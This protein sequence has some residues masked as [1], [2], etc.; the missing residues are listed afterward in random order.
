MASIRVRTKKD[1]TIY[2]AVLFREQGK[3]RSISVADPREAARAKK[4]IEQVGPTQAREILHIQDTTIGPDVLTTEQWLTRHIAALTGVEQATRNRYTGYV[5]RDITPA[6]GA[7]PLALLNRDHIAAWVNQL[8]G[9]AKTA[10]NKLRFL[11][12]AL[13]AAV[14]AGEIPANPAKGV[15]P[16]TGLRRDIVFLTPAEFRLIR[17]AMTPSWRPLAT[18]L[19]TTGTRFSEATALQVGDIDAHTST[20]RISRAWKY[21]DDGIERIGPPKSRAGIRIVNIP[22]STL[23]M[24]DL[25][26]AST[27]LL[28]AT[29]HGGRINAQLFYDNAWKPALDEVTADDADPRLTKRP[30]VHDLRHT[31]AS[32]LLNGGTPLLVVSRHL[33]H[34]SIKTT[35]DV[36]GHLD[37][38]AARLAADAIEGLLGGS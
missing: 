14:I 27:A 3:Q 25:D 20:A 10:S 30:R 21:S 4:L 38:S 29:E 28:F 16:P 33:G 24:L 2:H 1:G 9:S 13:N 19:V 6:F 8:E 17:D 26:R 23:A 12:G 35:S 34:A 15:R 32:W 18:W 37:R 31:N 36:Y 11:S 7:V 22:A 5:T